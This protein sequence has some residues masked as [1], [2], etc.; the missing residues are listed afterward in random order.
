MKLV[1]SHKPN[2]L[3][4]DIKGMQYHFPRQ[5]LSNVQNAVGDWIVYYE[6]LPRK[7]GRYYTAIARVAGIRPDVEQAN[8]YYADLVDYADF[9][10]LVP[11]RNNG[12]FEHNLVRADG[13]INGGYA[14]NSVR[15]ITI[16]EFAAILEA[17][18]ATP[19][20]WPDRIDDTPNSQRTIA[21]PGPIG[22]A[23]SGQPEII[24]APYNR[25]IIELLSNRKWRDIKFKQ[26][27]RVAYDRTCAFTGL[28]L[29]NGQGR[30]E[31]EAAHIRP[32]ERGGNDWARNGIALSGTLHWMF[33][34]GMLSMADDHSIL[35][36]RQLNHDVSHLLRHDLKAKVPDDVSLQPHPIYLDW[37]RTNVFKG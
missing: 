20:E 17:G 28:R 35:I 21:A 36:S 26:N 34:R 12:G 31:V 30:P 22:F 32:V 29:I 11:Y 13:S 18:M 19:S 15:A 1:F 16:L 23:E 7:A 25:P 37:H 2:G 14:I 9:D 3:Y 10:S 8:R 4:D 24:D 27:I 6:E 33:D 5:Y